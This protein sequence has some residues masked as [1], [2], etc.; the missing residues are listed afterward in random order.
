MSIHVDDNGLPRRDLFQI[1][2]AVSENP[3]LTCVVDEFHWHRAHAG[4][5]DNGRNDS[6]HYNSGCD[7]DGKPDPSSL[8][9]VL[10]LVAGCYHW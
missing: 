5:D 2:P 8:P 9:C 7:T 1:G 4:S 10:V 6:D 3:C